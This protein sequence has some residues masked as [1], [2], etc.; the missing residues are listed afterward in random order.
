MQSVAASVVAILRTLQAHTSQIDFFMGQRDTCST[1][2]N[3][4]LHSTF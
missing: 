3:A 4:K 1:C 2:T